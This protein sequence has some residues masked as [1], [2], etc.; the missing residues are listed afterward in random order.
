MNLAFPRV[1]IASLALLAGGC[2]SI[3]RAQPVDDL[4]GTGDLGIVIERASGSVLVVENS[5]DTRLGRIE[6]LGDLSHA[7]AVF[8]RDGRY[9]YVFGRDGGLTRIDLLKRRIDK[10][11]IQAGNSIGG[12]ISQDGRIVAAQNYEPGG[13]RLFDAVTLELLSEVRTFDEATGRPSKVVGLADLP[14]NRFAYALFDGGEIQVLDASDPRNPQVTRHTG[15]GRQPYDGLGS[16]NGRYYIAGLYGEDGLALI[17]FWQPQPAARR[18]LDGY[19]RGEQALPVY[20]MPHLR[21]WALSDGRAFFPAIGHAAVLVADTRDW[22]EIARVPV[23]GQP[24]FAMVSPDGRQV[25]VNFAYPHNDTVQVID[26]QSL[27]VVHTMQPCKGVLHFEFAPRGNEVWLSCRDDNRVE[28]YDTG[29][30]SRK[31][32]LEAATPSGIFFTWRASRLGM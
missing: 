17:D 4:R 22:Q 3:E 30:F 10:R 21:G 2:A 18:I 7:A 24:V 8:S 32:T 14:G 9:A 16:M 31:A 6:G 25:W 27:S 12:A 15:I 1:L 13:V 23:A 26:V 19:G 20:K 5:T 28:V 11:I 29:D